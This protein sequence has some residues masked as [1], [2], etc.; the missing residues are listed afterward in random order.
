MYLFILYG[1]SHLLLLSMMSLSKVQSEKG[2][3]YPVWIDWLSFWRFTHTIDVAV[4]VHA[5]IIRS[6]IWRARTW[7]YSGTLA[8]IWHY[9]SF[10]FSIDCL[11]HRHLNNILSDL[12][13]CS[14]YLLCDI[15]LISTTHV[16]KRLKQV[17]HSIALYSNVFLIGTARKRQR[18]RGREKERERERDRQT[19]R[20]KRKK[21]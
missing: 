17:D 9:L 2:L 20:E 12:S 7:T 10:L 19:E 16:Y 18:E 1:V 13:V 4:V 21:K 11:F 3:A 8:F 14:S 5:K 6:K 15:A